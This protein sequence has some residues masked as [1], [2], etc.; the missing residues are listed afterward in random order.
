MASKRD[1]VVK[2]SSTSPHYV[3]AYEGTNGE[4]PWPLQGEY[5]TPGS[6]ELAIKVYQLE[7][8]GELSGTTERKS[9][10]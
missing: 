3:I 6:A 7:K 9:G 5:T 8:S 1:L 2:Q 4:I 10:V